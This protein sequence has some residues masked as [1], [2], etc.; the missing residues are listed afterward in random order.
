MEDF[1]RGGIGF[2]TEKR[3]DIHYKGDCLG[4]H[5]L[6][7]VVERKIIVELKAVNSLEKFYQS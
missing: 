4:W 5:G 3:Y 1:E 7:L 6:D 2:E